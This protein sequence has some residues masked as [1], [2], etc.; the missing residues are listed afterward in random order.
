MSNDRIVR[1]ES[2][3]ITTRLSL[4]FT[5]ILAWIAWIVF[6]EN[7]STSVARRKISSLSSDEEEEEEDDDEETC[8]NTSDEEG[9]KEAPSLSIEGNFAN[10]RVRLDEDRSTVA[11]CYGLLN[12]IDSRIGRIFLRV[13]GRNDHGT[14]AAATG[15]DD[16]VTK[17]IVVVDDDDY[18]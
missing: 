11:R 6:T 3:I 14:I 13:F 15:A 12:D 2:L 4:L 17:T 16:N 9:E 10:S 7:S 1:R 18:S 8:E 5:I